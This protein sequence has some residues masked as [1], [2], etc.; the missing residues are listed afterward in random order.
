ME[1]ELPELGDD[2]WVSGPDVIPDWV[3]EVHS[4]QVHPL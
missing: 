4:F 1:A 3:K 2:F